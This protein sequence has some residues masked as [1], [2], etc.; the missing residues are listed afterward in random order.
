MKTASLPPGMAARDKYRRSHELRLESILHKLGD[1][2]RKGKKK[3]RNASS[4]S[5]DDDSTCT[6]E[7]RLSE[8]SIASN[9][10]GERVKYPKEKG[11]NFSRFIKNHAADAVFESTSNDNHASRLRVEAA[12]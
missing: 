7:E 9:K 8:K 5:G 6:D 11:S 3:T 2:S 12:R 10:A 1:S 4:Q